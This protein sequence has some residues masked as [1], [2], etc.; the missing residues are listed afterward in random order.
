MEPVALSRLETDLTATVRRHKDTIRDT[1]KQLK[2]AAEQLAE[3]RRR[4]REMGIGYSSVAGRR[5][6]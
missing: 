4:C 2:V 3:V 6:E 5:T 1:K